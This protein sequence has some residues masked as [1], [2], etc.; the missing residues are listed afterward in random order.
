MHTVIFLNQDIP[1]NTQLP[2]DDLEHPAEVIELLRRVKCSMNVP[3]RLTLDQLFEVMCFSSTFFSCSRYIY[4][5][6]V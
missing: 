2:K 1:D 3:E 6:L 4:S 5:S